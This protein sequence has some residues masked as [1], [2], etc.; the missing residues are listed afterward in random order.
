MQDWK[1]VPFKTL[2]TDSAGLTG[3]IAYA[4][5]GVVFV[6]AATFTID[7]VLTATSTLAFS[8]SDYWIE[9]VADPITFA[10]A[11]SRVRERPFTLAHAMNI[12]DDVTVAGG[13]ANHTPIHQIIAD[14]IV[15]AGQAIYIK[16]GGAAALTDAD[17]VTKA[18][19]AGV[20]RYS[21]GGVTG[22]N[23]YYVTDGDLW[24]EDWT[25]VI[26]GTTLTPGAVYYLS[27]TAGKLTSTPPTG[28]GE[29]VVKV[30][31]ALTTMTLDIELGEGTGL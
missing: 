26:G 31:R 30:G 6:Q 18:S 1:L 17:D 23:L 4:A 12:S 5:S 16:S 9:G 28:D 19:V 2:G 25:N 8:Q 7:R 24:M 10:Q 22:G 13:Q 15:L 20:A 29:F 3:D 21:G 14:E 27:T 11:L